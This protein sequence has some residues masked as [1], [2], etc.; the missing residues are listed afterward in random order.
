MDDRGFLIQVP[1]TLRCLAPLFLFFVGCANVNIPNMNDNAFQLEDDERRLMIRSRDVIEAIDTS[2]GLY[3]DR[4]LDNYLTGI[5]R[6]F[7]PPGHASDYLDVQVRVIRDPFTNAF[8]LPNGR[9][10][11]HSGMLAMLDNEA[12]LATVLAHEMT[13]VLYRHKLKENRSYTNKLAFFATLN[14]PLGVL[15]FGPIF[16]QL[17]ALSSITGY[18]RSLEYEADEHGF[19]ELL[20]HGYD[21]NESPKTFE[22]LKIFLEDEEVEVPFFFSTHPHV[23]DR[24]KNFEQF[25]ENRKG[26]ISTQAKVGREE[27]MAVTRDLKL[28]TI[29]LWMDNGMFKTAQ[30]NLD[31]FL[32]YFPDSADGFFLKGELLR[33]KKD[34]GED[35]LAKAL[36]AYDQAI[37]LNAQMA[38]AY[39]GKGRVFKRLNEP[40]KAKEAFEKYLALQPGAPDRLYIEEAIRML[41]AAQ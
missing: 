2:G 13:H 34:K 38:D 17:T 30:K 20:S 8:A 4:A 35:N 31:R 26:Q 24:I 33:Q 15:A 40:A 27:F 3:Q 29:S 7:V 1:G 14:A 10:Y 28:D 23:V 36:E 16:N 41:E 22:R 5:A 32:E 11:F 39:K 18:T 37:A 21:V 9:I 6:Q 19:G 25:K 12:Q